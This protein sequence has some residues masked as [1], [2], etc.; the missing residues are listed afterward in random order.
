MKRVLGMAAAWVFFFT[1]IS[2]AA[3][4]QY[5]A[6]G[7]LFVSN[8]SVYL[9]HGVD[10]GC[11]VAATWKAES[12][13]MVQL[14][15]RHIADI[16]QLQGKLLSVTVTVELLPVSYP[17]DHVQ[18]AEKLK[19]FDAKSMSVGQYEPPQMWPEACPKKV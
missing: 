18:Q 1:S 17:S 12:D 5:V 15:G 16:K 13:M 6:E 14:N 10:P 2:F 11:S 9:K 19:S 7:Y 4:K 3:E 8:G